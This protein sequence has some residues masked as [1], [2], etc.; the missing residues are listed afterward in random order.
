M[1]AQTAK[2]THTPGPWEVDGNR[3]SEQLV[4]ISEFGEVAQVFGGDNPDDETIPNALLIAAAPDLL[5][6]CKQMV[7]WCTC[8]IAERE[9]GHHVDCYVP[10]VLAL[11][12]K[13]DGQQ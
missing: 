8:S 11:I 1:S 5:D 13:A 7:Q 3:A 9:S 4:I 12:A 6:A 2:A 10:A